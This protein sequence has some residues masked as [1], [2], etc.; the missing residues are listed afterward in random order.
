MVL[1]LPKNRMRFEL[2]KNMDNIRSTNQ[3]N[4]TNIL[5]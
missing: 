1:D 2:T 4:F 3:T 5:K